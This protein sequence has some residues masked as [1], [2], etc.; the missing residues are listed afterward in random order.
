MAAPV[1]PSLSTAE[2]GMIKTVTRESSQMDKLL[3]AGSKCGLNWIPR[4]RDMGGYSTTQLLP[5]MYPKHLCLHA[6][7]VCQAEKC[8]VWLDQWD[9]NDEP[10]ILRLPR[11][12]R[13]RQ[14]EARTHLCSEH[15]EEYLEVMGNRLK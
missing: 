12:S 11:C 4:P 6:C 3:K 1:K 13:R 5:A 7:N 14:H 2:S 9:N 15:L 10:S 8:M